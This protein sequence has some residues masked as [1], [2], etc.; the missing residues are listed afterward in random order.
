MA[1]LERMEK[2]HKDSVQREKYEDLASTHTFIIATKR[3]LSENKE[4]MLRVALTYC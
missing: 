3:R 2:R 1:I 4:K